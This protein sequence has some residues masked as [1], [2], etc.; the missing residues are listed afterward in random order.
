[1]P[2]FTAAAAICL[3]ALPAAAQPAPAI[4]TFDPEAY[5]QRSMRTLNQNSQFLLNAC[6]EQE[7]ASYDLLKE[8]WE[9][10]PATIRNHCMRSMRTISIT[11]YFMLQACVEQEVQSGRANQR[12]Q[13]RR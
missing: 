11:S 13:F 3:L 7:Q 10:T 4:P 5:C 2:R 12:F 9:A 8:S 6:L 1:M